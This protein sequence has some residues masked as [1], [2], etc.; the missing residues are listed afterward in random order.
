MTGRALRAFA[1]ALLL[2]GVLARAAEPTMRLVVAAAPGGGVDRIARLLAQRF[3]DDLHRTV[4]V[5]NRPGGANRIALRELAQAAPDGDTLLLTTGASTI[6]L[7]FDAKVRPNIIDDAAPVAL[8]A[9]TP[10]AFL[11]SAKSPMRSI[12]DV[13]AR[14][15]A[16][17]GALNYGSVNVQSTQRVAGELF[18][19]G[20]RTDIA[21][22]PY[23]SE[24]AIL[25]ALVAGDLDVAVVTLASALPMIR[26]SEV[27]VL[28]ISG[29]ARTPALPD[30]PTL[31]EAGIAGVT[32]ETWCGVFAPRA[33]PP[34]KVAALAGAIRRAGESPEYR[35]ALAS[36]GEELR[37]GSPATFDAMLH[38]ELARFREV[39]DVAHLRGP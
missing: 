26:A 32:L 23:K 3:Q 15:R 7:A 12:A 34:A 8:V 9:V 18:K 24:I 21:Q 6:D 33:T 20:T 28:A 37:S 14:A 29:T 10:I 13:V 31:A 4:V 27:R 38:A 25:A 35:R 11:A 30:V 19:L 5:E 1:A 39:I 16:V 2:V 36:M 22:I 17:P